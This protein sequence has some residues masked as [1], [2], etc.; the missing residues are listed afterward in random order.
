MTSSSTLGSPAANAPTPWGWV[1]AGVLPFLW[2]SL[3]G[4]LNWSVFSNQTPETIVMA[5]FLLILLVY[6]VLFILAYKRSFPAWSY[7]LVAQFLLLSLYLAQT[8]FPGLILFGAAFGRQVM[9]HF[10]FFPLLLALVMS[11]LLSW[12]NNQRLMRSTFL[13][14]EKNIIYLSF[15]FYGITTLLM[16]M[17]FDGVRGEELFLV[18]IDLL[19]AAGAVIFLRSRE[20]YVRA[21]ALVGGLLAAWVSSSIYLGIYW[22]GRQEAWMQSPANG[23]ESTIG[24]LVC[25]MIVIL[26]TMVPAIPY[27][28]DRRGRPVYTD[29]RGT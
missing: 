29:E 18:A 5:S 4:L 12:N 26:L 21:G 13:D 6:G 19:L 2:I 3:F 25:G 14:L 23:M 1:L 27:L 22:D 16:R 10:A 7:A 15:G 11:L 20:M 9:G 17:T 28:F 8:S 24:N